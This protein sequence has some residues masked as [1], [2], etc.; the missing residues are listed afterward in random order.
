MTSGF[1]ISDNISLNPVFHN[2][3]GFT[4]GEVESI[5][6]QSAIPREIILEMMHDLKDSR[7]F[8]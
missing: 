4:H 1:N 7:P 5:L 6:A 8:I 3:M 2:M